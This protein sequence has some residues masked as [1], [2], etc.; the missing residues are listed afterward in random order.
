[1]TVSAKGLAWVVLGAALAAGPAA[2]DWR[3]VPAGEIAA[4]LLS[5]DVVYGDLAWER[6]AADGALLYRSTEGPLGRTSVGEWRLEQDAR[7]LRWNRAVPFEC[8]R[9]ERDGADG[10]RFVDEWGNASTGRLVPRGAGAE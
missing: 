5:H 4:L 1:M 6:H 3:A 8:Y 10:I 9:V 7:C 2:A